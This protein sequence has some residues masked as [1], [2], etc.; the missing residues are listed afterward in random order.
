M[1]RVDTGNVM[2]HGHATGKDEFAA[3]SLRFP[4]LLQASMRMGRHCRLRLCNRCAR[5][6]E[7]RERGQLFVPSRR[8]RRV[9]SRELSRRA[10]PSLG[11]RAR[12]QD[13]PS[14]GC[15]ALRVGPGG[16]GRPSDCGNQGNCK[17]VRA[18]GKPQRIAHVR[19]AAKR[20]R[21]ARQVPTTFLS[22]SVPTV[23]FLAV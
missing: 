14:R 23:L 2:T 5:R 8:R 7:L 16:S 18:P 11:K 10:H 17:R 6:P 15:C 1:S 13:S 9:W 4:M 19:Q 12:R 20:A 3:F 22:L 21:S